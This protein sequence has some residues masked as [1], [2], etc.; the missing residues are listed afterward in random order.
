[1]FVF[2]IEAFNRKLD[3]KIFKGIPEGQRGDLIGTLEA[4]FVIDAIVDERSPDG[5]NFVR[6]S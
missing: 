5:G 2:L 3:F 4:M 1:M 6:K